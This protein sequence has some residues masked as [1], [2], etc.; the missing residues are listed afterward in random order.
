ML[1]PICEKYGKIVSQYIRKNTNSQ[2][3]SYVLFTYSDIKVAIKAKQELNRRKDLLG[4]KRVE[5][6]LLLDENIILKN[7]DL[8][9]T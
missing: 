4:D 8:S 3:R 5:V 6:T 2:N 9:H 7:R 1:R